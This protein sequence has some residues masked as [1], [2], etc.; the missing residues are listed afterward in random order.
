M[1]R[2][3]FPKT[4]A[5]RGTDFPYTDPRIAYLVAHPVDGL[6]QPEREDLKK[7]AEQ[8]AKGSIVLL[9]AWPGQYESDVFIVDDFLAFSAAVAY[10]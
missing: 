4:S 3:D 6:W 1:S 8:L 9:A 10:L 7:V 5:V 2:Y